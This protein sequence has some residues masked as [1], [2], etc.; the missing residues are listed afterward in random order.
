VAG[1][2]ARYAESRT[3]TAAIAPTDPPGHRTLAIAP[4]TSLPAPAARADCDY[5]PW[6]DGDRWSQGLTRRHSVAL[7]W[8]GGGE[9]VDEQLCDALGLVVMHPVRGAEQALNTVQ[10][11]HVVVVGLG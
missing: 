2:R 3:S 5:D 1:S 8:F 4:S 9:E 10:V 7:G 6:S 11:G